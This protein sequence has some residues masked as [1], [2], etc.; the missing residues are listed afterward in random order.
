MKRIWVCPGPADE[1]EDCTY[2]QSAPGWCPYHPHIDLDPKP[3]AQTTVAP[4]HPGL[5]NIEWEG[6][7]NDFIP[8]SRGSSS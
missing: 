1:M 6:V 7:P 8:P 5:S 4:D 2:W 3:L